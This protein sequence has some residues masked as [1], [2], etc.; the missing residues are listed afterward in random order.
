MSARRRAVR[1]SP[2]EQPGVER[3]GQRVSGHERRLRVKV[4]LDVALGSD[5]GAG[6]QGLTQ[7]LL[8]AAEGREGCREERG[9]G[10]LVC[11]GTLNA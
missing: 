9:L 3:L 11:S 8:L 10:D 6:Q 1:H 5:D 4:L 7:L 2:V